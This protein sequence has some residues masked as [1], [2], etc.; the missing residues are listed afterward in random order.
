MRS[1]LTFKFGKLFKR[2]VKKS[3]VNE[4]TTE[5]P[6]GGAAGVDYD[7]R[8]SAPMAIATVYRCVKLLG[9]MTASMPLLLERKSG[10]IWTEADRWRVPYLLNVQPYEALNAYDFK[11]M[12]VAALLIKGN[13]YILPFWS[14]ERQ[15]YDRFV[16]LT[17]GST[18]FDPLARIYRVNDIDNGITG[19]FAERDIIH[20][21]GLRLIGR[22]GVGVITYARQTM[23][24][25]EAGNTETRERFLSGGH[26]R[27]FISGEGS[28]VY[29][30]G[31]L[32]TNELNAAARQIDVKFR[33]GERIV[34]L[35]GALTF[36]EL[37]L[38][39]ADM[40]F[41]ETRKFTV[42]EICRFFGVHPSFVFDDTSNNYKS[43]EMANVAFLSQTLNPLL[44]QIET[45]ILRKLFTESEC[46]RY[47]VRFDRR[48]LNAC[49]LDARL[50]WQTG[51]I[52]A[53]LDT[54]N[55][56]READGKQPVED[57]DLSLVS[58][59]LKPLCLLKAESA[60]SATLNDIPTNDDD[61]NA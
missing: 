6:I 27:G 26:V 28:G 37:T 16:L 1:L 2:E 8:C 59:N 25:A 41:L 58:A 48:E 20:I 43:A 14:E 11:T 57:G 38:S 61:N 53:G 17:P 52:A 60:T 13:A 39:S 56:A 12:L 24:T 45:E 31:E 23:A 40:Q 36:K 51:R 19:D 18:Y 22:E 32:Q 3:T 46:R 54:V 55:E 47:R 49:D 15:S 44:R 9:D 33:N 10:N 4:A 30:Y 35:P 29:G 7:A 34:R 42:R 5:W 50:R 21:C